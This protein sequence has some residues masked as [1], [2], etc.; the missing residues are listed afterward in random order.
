MPKVIYCVD[1]THSG[2][3]T[4]ADTF[5]LGIGSIAAMAKKE[6]GANS[7]PTFVIVGPTGEAQK[8][9]GAHPYSTFVSVLDQML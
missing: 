9:V 2:T 7:T 4:N 6:F 3:I 5:P 8:I 1:L